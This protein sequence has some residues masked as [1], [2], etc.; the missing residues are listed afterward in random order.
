MLGGS[1]D[2]FCLQECVISAVFLPPYGE[3]GAS[4]MAGEEVR[5]EK[6]KGLAYS[7]PCHHP[8]PTCPPAT[9]PCLSHQAP[10]LHPVHP[11]AHLAQEQVLS[12][13]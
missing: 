6:W 4:S 2:P 9:D 10:Y 5:T 11:P 3:S 7:P 13:W 1:K 12:N 8:L